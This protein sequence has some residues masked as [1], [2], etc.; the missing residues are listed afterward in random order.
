METNEA[1]PVARAGPTLHTP[2]PLALLLGGFGAIVF[3]ILVA[4]VGV[5]PHVEDA[6]RPHRPADFPAIFGNDASIAGLDVS[7]V[8]TAAHAVVVAPG[9]ALNKDTFPCSQ[10][11]D[12]KD[13]KTN[14]EIRTKFRDP[15]DEL[16]FDHRRIWC[17]D[18]HDT[19]DR[20]KLK[21]ANGTLL[22]LTD[23][24]RLCSQ[25]HGG[26]A[27]E[28]EGGVHGKRTGFWDGPKRALPCIQCHD[29]HSPHFKKLEPLPPPVRPAFLR[30]S[31]LDAP[32]TAAT[33]EGDHDLPGH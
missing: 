24:L 13:L 5:K 11:H 1:E 27:R 31:G 14:F 30:S 17:L 4:L 7:A 3:T 8:G 15:H 26:I 23:P 2:S 16:V 33:K 10:C 6:R 19:M 25:C 20:D 29:P 28:W 21:L 32:D 22:P 12:N 18:C 9:P